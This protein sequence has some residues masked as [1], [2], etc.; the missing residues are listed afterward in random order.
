MTDMSSRLKI[1]QPGP[2][3]LALTAFSNLHGISMVTMETN[4]L[5][6]FLHR[7]STFPPSLVPFCPF[8]AEKKAVKV[9]PACTSSPLSLSIYGYYNINKKC[10]LT[11]KRAHLLAIL[12]IDFTPELQL[13]IAMKLLLKEE[14]LVQ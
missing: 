3:I 10:N 12:L 5:T 14:V 7:P 2:H 13:V 8:T 11:L 9:T 4:G 6:N 1:Q